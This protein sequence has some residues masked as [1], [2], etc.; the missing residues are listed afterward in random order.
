SDG[1]T[2]AFAARDGVTLPYDQA[3]DDDCRVRL[4]RVGPFMIANDTL[5]CGGLN[6]TFTGIYQVGR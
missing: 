6:V 5:H 4:R 1:T 3:T 2:I